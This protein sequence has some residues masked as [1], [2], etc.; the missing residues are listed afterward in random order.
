MTN[1]E[2][3]LLISNIHER[4]GCLS[5]FFGDLLYVAEKG[6]FPVVVDESVYMFSWHENMLI[7]IADMLADDGVAVDKGSDQC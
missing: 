7:T 1:K 4:A 6:T 2:L 5:I 3:R